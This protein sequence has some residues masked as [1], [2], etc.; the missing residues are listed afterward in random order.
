MAAGLSIGTLTFG[1]PSPLIGASIARF[2]PR[3]N[4]VLGNLLAAL[5]LAGVSL[6]QEVWHLYVFYGIGGIGVG[7]GM[8]V[9]CTTVVNNWFIQK[10]SLGMGLVVAAGGLGGFVFPL[11]VT[12]LISTI[13]W[14]LSWVVLAGIHLVFAVLIGG[15][16]LVRNKPEDLGQ[17]PDGVSIEPLGREEG[18]GR[19]SQVYQSPVDWR[20]KQA[21]RK[22]TTWL[23]VA[24]GA[25]NFFAIGAVMSHQ[26]AYL[27]DIGFTSMIAAMALSLVSGMSIIGRLGFGALALRFEVRR[28]AIFSFVVQLVALAIL[29]TTKNLALIYIYAALFGISYGAL[30]TSLPTFVGGY[31]GRTHYA[32]ILGLIFPLTTVA[33]AV[34]PVLAGAIYDV[35]ATYTL[36][37]IVVIAFSSAGLICA[38]LARPP[39]LNQ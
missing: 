21:M 31:Y 25:A 19:H 2:G 18:A 32:Q 14:Q 4:I 20:T 23:I 29:L 15:V 22:P 38:I 39:K 37:F 9:A 8:Y 5:A 3:V 10:R 26:V 27:K 1:L 34:G 7:F 13:G 16:I 11:L 36:A 6:T 17:V 12:W 33:E 28:L 24:I 35:T 30:I